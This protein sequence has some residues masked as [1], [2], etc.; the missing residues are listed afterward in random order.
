MISQV[1]IAFFTLLIALGSDFYCNRNEVRHRDAASVLSAAPSFFAIGFLLAQS[2]FGDFLVWLID[3]PLPCV[4][5]LLIISVMQ[6]IAGHLIDF[7]IALAQYAKRNNMTFAD[8]R[9]LPIEDL[10]NISTFG[11]TKVPIKGAG[12]YKMHPRHV[13][14]A[15]LCNVTGALCSVCVLS[16]MYSL[17]GISDYVILN[18]NW[19]N[20]FELVIS[21]AVVIVLWHIHDEQ[22]GPFPEKIDEFAEDPDTYRLSRVHVWA[23]SIHLILNIS[24][25]IILVVLLLLFGFSNFQ[26]CSD[27]I[28]VICLS[29]AALAAAL[30]LWV[31]TVSGLAEPY[32][33]KS[34]SNWTVGPIVIIV[35]YCALIVLLFEPAIINW[36]IA[37]VCSALIIFVRVLIPIKKPGAFSLVPVFMLVAAFLCM[38]LL[39]M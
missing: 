12:R 23:N 5:L 20:I 18:S 21:V 37:A 16:M 30:F 39:T 9:K 24:V 31:S 26:S 15:T 29:V 32:N 4:F 2:S 28:P 17:P 3:N 27:I 11:D 10:R 38:F 22:A 34:K 8:A 19:V 25:C 1:L 35:A 13:L 33:P 14:Y 7:P 36:V 6:P